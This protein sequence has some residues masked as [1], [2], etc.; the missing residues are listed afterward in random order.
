MLNPHFTHWRTAGLW[1]WGKSFGERVTDAEIGQL[2]IVGWFS[3]PAADPA[4]IL[5]FRAW[6]RLSSPSPTAPAPCACSPDSNAGR[7]RLSL[8]GGWRGSVRGD[9]CSRWPDCC[10]WHGTNGG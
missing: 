2:K 9:S 4:S 3:T 7:G 1:A 6:A 10:G 8:P 5:A